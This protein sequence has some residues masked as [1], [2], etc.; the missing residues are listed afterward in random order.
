MLIKNLTDTPAFE[1]GDLTRIQ[2]ILHPKNDGL[3]LP[4][5]LAV[6]SLEPGA[7]SVLHMLKSSLEIYFILEGEGKVFLNT[8]SQNVKKGD[9][10]YIAAGIKQH[11]ENTGRSVLTFLCIVAPPWHGADE[12]I[13]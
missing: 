1:A 7:K 4:F 10:V 11:I 8:E 5:S 13:F 6:A 2:E 9:L 12:Y 3:D